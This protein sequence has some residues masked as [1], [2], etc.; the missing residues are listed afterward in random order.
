M[1]H[2]I[3]QSEIWQGLLSLSPLALVFFMVSFWEPLFETVPDRNELKV[4]TGNANVIGK[5]GGSIDTPN[6]TLAIKYECLCD[7]G[8]GEKNFE[9]GV[10]VNSLGEQKDG[11]Y[12][13]WELKIG[14]SQIFTYD[15]IASKKLENVRNAKDIAI[16]GIIISMA[17]MLLLGMRKLKERKT[18]AEKSIL[19]GLLDDLS[20]NSKPDPERLRCL[21]KILYYDTNDFI[22]AL[23]VIAMNNTNSEIFLNRVGIELGGF[24]SGMEVEEIEAVTYVQPA[25]KISAVNVMRAKNIELHRKLQVIGAVNA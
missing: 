6:G 20:D 15:D 25:A 5:K 12:N 14:E 7:Y 21:D 24:W 3:F 19:F 22:E 10:P 9:K 16:P 8:W 11:E 2:K 17:L 1:M 13:I 4:I 18:Q 23:E